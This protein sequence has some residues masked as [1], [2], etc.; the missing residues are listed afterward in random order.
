MNKTTL[1]KNIVHTLERNGCH[2]E[3][4]M[5]RNNSPFF[6][7]DKHEYDFMVIASPTSSIPGKITEV[8]EQFGEVLSATFRSRDKE[9]SHKDYLGLY[10]KFHKENAVEKSDGT[11]KKE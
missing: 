11:T 7:D 3:S 2:L 4:W 8:A 5:H 10:W 6:R 1:V 9:K